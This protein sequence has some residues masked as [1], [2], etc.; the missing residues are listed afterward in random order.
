MSTPIDS[1][2]ETALESPYSRDREEAIE[3]LRRVYPGADGDGKRRILETLR[4]VA[5]ESSSR[6]ERAL[7][8]ETLQACFDADATAAKQIVVE[9]FCGLAEDSKFS[10]ERLAAIDT[11]REL[12][13][14]TTDQSRETI[15]R[16]LAEIAGNATY[17]DERRRARQRLSDISRDERADT[18]ADTGTESG[19]DEAIGYLGESLAQHLEQA[20]H[21]GPEACRQRAEEVREF[22]S[23]HRLD[24][25]AYGD[26]RDDVDALVEQLSVVPTGDSLDEDRIKRVERIAAR[27][28][29]LYTRG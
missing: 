13:P 29:R 20:A 8:R 10:E 2:C 7:A 1:H 21:E 17:E 23:E 6:A 18:T 16:T 19:P 26:V 27:V 14:D 11:L 12:Y 15:G 28:E 25:A 3:E 24:D 4:Q 5:R 9:A 22:V